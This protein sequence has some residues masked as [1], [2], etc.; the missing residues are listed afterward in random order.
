MADVLI[1]VHVTPR[2]SRDEIVGWRDG[3]LAV[4]VT[5]PPDD[6]KANAAACRL[7]ASAL[8]LPKSAVTVARG[9]TSRHKAVRVQGVGDA[10]VA[11]AFGAPDGDSRE[12]GERG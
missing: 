2:V 8:G 4:R 3:E 10:D 9:A 11:R 1:A 5:S 6:G 7:V 12:G